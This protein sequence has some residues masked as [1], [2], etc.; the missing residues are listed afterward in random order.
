MSVRLAR[1]T[2][3]A[4][5]LEIY[6]PYVTDTTITFEYTVPEYEEFLA[7]FRSISADFPW[8]VWEEDGTVLG[9]AYASLPF[10]RAAYRWCSE[11]S[12]YLCSEARGRGIGTQLYRILEEL[13]TQMGYRILY[14]LI[15]AENSASVSFHKALGFSHLAEFPTCGLKFDRWIGVIWMEK[16]LILSEKPAKMPLSWGVFVKNNRNANSILD[17]L[18]LS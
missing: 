12:I 7:R 6:A 17:N 9:Y 18:T 4:R 1:E 5:M 15:T 10:Q 14:A 3:V 8:I 16:R 2:D 13:L 11:S